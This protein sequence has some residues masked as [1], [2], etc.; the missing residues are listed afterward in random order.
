MPRFISIDYGSKRTGLAWTDPMQIIATGIGTVDTPTLMKQLATYVEKEDIEGFVVG[1][2]TRSDG[3]STDATPLVMEF[4]K[5][6]DT[7]YP[8]MPIYPWD[9]QFTSQRAYESMIAS[10]VKRSQRS[11]KKLI[12]E[13]SA[14]LILQEFLDAADGQDYVLEEGDLP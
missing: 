7:Q 1:L 2:P 6:L 14:V 9:E 10:G 5:E 13:V 3:S 8:D 12:N 4:L 11:D